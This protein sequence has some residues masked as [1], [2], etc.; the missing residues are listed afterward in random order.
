[1]KRLCTV[2]F[3][4]VLL[5]VLLPQAEAAGP[6]TSYDNDT[7]YTWVF[8]SDGSE[9]SIYGIVDIG[10]YSAT[11]LEIPAYVRYKNE[12]T[13][14]VTGLDYSSVY[15]SYTFKNMPNLKKVILPVSIKSI[16]KQTF[17]DCTKLETVSMSSSAWLTEIGPT[18]FARCG[19]LKDF[20][21]PSSLTKISGSA[22]LDSGLTSID[23]S[24]TG[25]TEI[26]GNAFSNTNVTFLYL[27]ASIRTIG[28]NAFNTKSQ[29]SVR[30]AGSESQWNASVSVGSGNRF[31]TPIQFDE[32]L[33]PPPVTVSNTTSYSTTT[34]NAVVKAEFTASESGRWTR[35]GVRLYNAS[36]T[37]IASKEET[38]NYNMKQLSV[39]YDV[40]SELGKTLSPNTTYAFE[41]YTYFN[42]EQYTTSRRTF[43]TDV[44]TTL[45]WYNTIEEITSS[46]F[47]FTLEGKANTTG[48]FSEYTFTLKDA[49]TGKQLVNFTNNSDT[50]LFTTDASWFRLVSWNTANWGRLAEGHT[51]LYQASYV[52]NGTRYYSDWYYVN[53]PDHAAPWINEA[54]MTKGSNDKVEYWFIAKDGDKV[55]DVK[56]YVYND[57][58][59][60]DAKVQL[61]YDIETN[62]FEHWWWY[63]DNFWQAPEWQYY[64]KGTFDIDEVGGRKDCYYYL[65]FVVTDRS[66]N[67]TTDSTQAWYE[68][69]PSY[70]Q[71]IYAGTDYYPVTTKVDTALTSTTELQLDL[72]GGDVYG[73]SGFCIAVYPQNAGPDSAY[74]IDVSD[75]TYKERRQIN[76]IYHSIYTASTIVDLNALGLSSEENVCVDVYTVQDLGEYMSLEPMTAAVFIDRQPPRFSDRMASVDW[77]GSMTYDVNIID[78]S[79]IDT[80]WLSVWDAEDPDVSWTI[81]GAINNNHF[82][83]N[84][85]LSDYVGDAKLVYVQCCVR[86]ANQNYAESMPLLLYYGISPKLS[87]P[88]D[89]QVIED[90]AF[91]GVSE[92]AV[93]IPQG[94]VSIGSGAFSNSAALRYVFIPA[95][96]TSIAADAFSGSNVTVISP[97][98]CAARYYAENNGIAW[99]ADY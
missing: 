96:V 91:S 13:I 9:A 11:T 79:P 10:K 36:G 68:R 51:Y 65:Q 66:G 94:C 7:G 4:L 93:E 24:N 55:Q 98:G 85:S 15:W 78:A 16:A 25:I 47:K 67:V 42:G 71:R 38:H 58:D 6:L 83:A 52:F 88:A 81:G 69:E 95:N 99:I 53:T 43:K 22:F 77:D 19:K 74:W 62:E 2:F 23:L 29:V 54:S 39:W 41:I 21:F 40:N 61:D 73:V 44:K 86:D 17:A 63:E 90:Q 5:L 14:P 33:P 37:V 46:S 30:Y 27:P 57:V 92:Y 97:P 49:Q 45:T 64:G 8:Y 72:E 20:T 31:A 75:V 18:A 32:I 26:A 80:C 60:L 84:V 12:K 48:T 1:M 70:G 50:H 59:G 87:L 35:S 34:D 89:L 3:A 82:S 28:Q 56:C 76:G